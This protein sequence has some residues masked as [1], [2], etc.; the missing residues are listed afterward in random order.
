MNIKV[1][2]GDDHTL[3]RDGIRAVIDNMGEE[4]EIVGEASN[5]KEVLEMAKKT[6]A[7]VYI[8]DISMP[9][10]NGIE[11]ID[12][13][14]KMNP[15]NKIIIL[16]M[17]DDKTLVEKSLKSGA[18]GY[19]LKKNSAEEMI[20]AIREVHAGKFFLSP[21]ISKYIVQG[22][23]GK[24]SDERY[25]RGGPGLTR[26]EREILQLIAEGSTNKDVA[27]ELS[28][29]INTVNFHRKNMM[30][31]LDIHNQADLVRYALKEGI[32]EL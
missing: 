18:K 29:S 20:D 8:L 4:I 17:H 15:R 24:G 27:R 2:V 22:F 10:L 21:D 1:I 6:P 23:L 19:L 14:I 32:S 5:G 26:R 13:L 7:D 9:I 16:S 25:Y 28:L 12:R 3:V 30:K 11:T 31:K